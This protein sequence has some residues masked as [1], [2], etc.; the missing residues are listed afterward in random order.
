M[1]EK[2]IHKFYNFLKGFPEHHTLMKNLLLDYLHL[3][4]ENERLVTLNLE[5]LEDVKQYR[6]LLNEEKDFVL[7]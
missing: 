6:N 7:H 5:L 3:R 4:D 2:D 1:T